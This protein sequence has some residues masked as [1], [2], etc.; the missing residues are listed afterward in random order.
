MSRK[1]RSA[2]TR[3]SKKQTP[4]DKFTPAQVIAAL[5][6]SGGINV[7]AARMLRCSPS[8]I[9]NYVARYPEIAQA[10][11]EIEFERLDLAET[12]VI[13]RMMSEANLSL[14]L[15]AAMFY[16]KKKGADRGYGA[17]TTYDVLQHPRYDFSQLSGE[18]FKTLD[19]LL[20]KAK[21][22]PPEPSG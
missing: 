5:E 9:T 19:Q 7:A 17:H 21:K 18:E 3:L 13:K 16:L 11:K 2:A 22:A 8:T 10:K 4:K 14:Q 6:A 15:R 20:A 12:I 1:K